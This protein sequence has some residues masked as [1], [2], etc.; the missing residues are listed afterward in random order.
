MKKKQY[1][2]PA[3][4]VVKL[5]HTQML[6]QSGEYRASRSGYGKADTEDGTEQTWE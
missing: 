6:M 2:N 3:M 5:Q 1:E 4:T